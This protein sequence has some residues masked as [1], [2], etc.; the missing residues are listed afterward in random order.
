M[1]AL[2]G[3]RVLDLSRVLAGPLATQM[4]ADLGADVVKVEAPWGDDTRKWGPPF[5]DGDAAYYHACNRGKRSILLDIKSESGQHSLRQLI[6]QADVIVE[7]FKAGTLERMGLMTE[8]SDDK[9]LCRITGYG[10]TGPRAEEP[11]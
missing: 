1:S 5:I 7:N 10:Q 4:L 3:V 9:I 6:A 2:E 11:G 8:I